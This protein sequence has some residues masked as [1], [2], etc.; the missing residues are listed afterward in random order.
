MRTCVA[1]KNA[2]MSKIKFNSYMS[3]R[4]IYPTRC[5]Y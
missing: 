2:E 1:M 3:Q 5:T 4:H